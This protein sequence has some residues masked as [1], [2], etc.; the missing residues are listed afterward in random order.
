MCCKQAQ[1]GELMMDLNRARKGK[2]PLKDKEG[3]TK[4]NF[5]PEA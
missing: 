1:R 2:P 4:K 3:K 5:A